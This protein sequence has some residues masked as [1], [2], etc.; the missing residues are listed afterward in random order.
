[1]ANLS[2]NE[3]KQ[4]VKGLLSPKRERSFMLLATPGLNLMER[5]RFQG[6]FK[7]VL[8]KLRGAAPEAEGIGI[9]TAQNPLKW[10]KDPAS[11]P[12]SDRGQSAYNLVSN[13]ALERDLRDTG[14]EFWTIGG[15]F[16]GDVEES[17]IVKNIDADDVERLA[18][19]YDQEAFIHGAFI[20][21]GKYARKGEEEKERPAEDQ[22]ESHF[23]YYDIDYGQE[24]G[25]Y[26]VE[27]RTRIFTDS[28]IQS[29]EDFYSKV[30]GKKFLIPFFDT[31]E[32]TLVQT[33]A[34]ERDLAL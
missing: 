31:D 20:N 29:R 2:L 34:P 21:I 9:L 30:S 5:K 15:R 8:D 32:D 33:M 13:E 19:K 10:R 22:Y 24:Q 7:K 16:G 4:M 12:A 6:Q 1:M 17:Y 18:R 14:Y 11:A 28:D 25:A 23:T 26:P 3:M 27:T